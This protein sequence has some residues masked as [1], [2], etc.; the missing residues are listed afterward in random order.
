MENKNISFCQSCGMPLNDEV[1]GTEL[2]NSTNS[3]HC[4]YCYKDG[5]FTADITME[6]MIEFCIPHM[7]NANKDITEDKA[8]SMMHE[9]FP[10]L[11]RWTK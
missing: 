8:R 10:T 2:D 5:N 3:D 9:F 6:Q 4:I 7:I 11:K 1:L